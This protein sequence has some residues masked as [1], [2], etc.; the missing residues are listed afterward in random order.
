MKGLPA[1]A[2]F[3]RYVYSERTTADYIGNDRPSGNEYD[4]IF[5]GGINDGWSDFNKNL[6]GD[7]DN[8]CLFPMGEIIPV[9]QQAVLSIDKF[10]YIVLQM[11]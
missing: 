10:S 11:N 9:D 4:G 8:I 3:T 1:G 2:S 7:S 5:K 6:A